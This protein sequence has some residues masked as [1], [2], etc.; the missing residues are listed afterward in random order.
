MFMEEAA[1]HCEEV[2]FPLINLLV[3]CSSNKN[4]SVAI[5]KIKVFLNLWN[6]KCPE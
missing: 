2:C 3:Q 5:L 1:W 6:K 4:A